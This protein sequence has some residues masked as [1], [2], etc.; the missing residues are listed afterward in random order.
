MASMKSKSGKCSNFGNC[1]TADARA[2]VEVPGGLDFVC[3]ECGKPLLLSDTGPQSGGSKT[4]LVGGLLLAMLLL[5]GG[6]AWFFLAG[7]KSAE[8]MPPP[9]MQ[10]PATPAVIAPAPPPAPQTETPARPVSG[11]C[12]PADERAGLCR[13]AP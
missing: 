5:G 13:P 7:E 2:T 4:L 10:A 11:H 8:P 6:A 1:A 9:A 3:N 12:S